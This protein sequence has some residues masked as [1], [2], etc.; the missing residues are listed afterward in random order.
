M[1]EY[2]RIS[3]LS[4][5]EVQYLDKQKIQ[6][7]VGG[8]ILYHDLTSLSTIFQ[9]AIFMYSSKSLLTFPQKSSTIVLEKIYGGKNLCQKNLLLKHLQD[10]FM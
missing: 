8:S 5:A 6:D 7:L 10:T 3:S 9:Y 1:Q 4:D 2:W